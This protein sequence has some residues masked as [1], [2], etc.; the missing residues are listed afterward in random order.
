MI[1]DNYPSLHWDNLSK[2]DDIVYDVRL[3]FELVANFSII[4]DWHI[5]RVFL[6]RLTKNKLKEKSLDCF[7]L[8]IWKYI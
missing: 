5:R 3:F 6:V 8:I 7:N 1:D 4:N 2:T